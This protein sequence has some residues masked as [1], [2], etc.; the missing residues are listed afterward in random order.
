MTTPEKIEHLLNLNGDT[1][2]D[3]PN[4]DCYSRQQRCEAVGKALRWR[5]I[6]R[7]DRSVTNLL[8][9]FTCHQS[10]VIEKLVKTN[11]AKPMTM[12]DIERIHGINLAGTWPF[13]TPPYL[14]ITKKSA[15]SQNGWICWRDICYI[16]ENRDERL[17]RKNYGSCWR[18]W[19]KKPTD[20]QTRA[21]K[22]MQHDIDELLE[23][24][25][26]RIPDML[27]EELKKA[28]KK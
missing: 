12:E 11:E 20:E 8:I 17:N 2:S 15:P 9:E 27:Y 22:W 24:I 26:G 14:W 16:L 28:I 4:P 21:V 5:G 6:V 1:L 25:Q 23:E 7:A 13:N 19:T 18:L 10:D 3:L